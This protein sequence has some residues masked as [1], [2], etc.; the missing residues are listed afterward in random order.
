MQQSSPH[1][2][3]GLISVTLQIL[4]PWLGLGS[5][6]PVGR[7]C[8]WY[9]DHT[10]QPPVSRDVLLGVARTRWLRGGFGEPCLSEGFRSVETPLLHTLKK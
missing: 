2:S 9:T 6:F 1:D 8:C 7:R 5:A 4:I 10:K 3:L